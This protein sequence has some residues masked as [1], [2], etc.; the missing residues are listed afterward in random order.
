MP[1]ILPTAQNIPLAEYVHQRIARL[2]KIRPKKVFIGA[3]TPTRLVATSGSR[4]YPK[5]L[6]LRG[7]VSVA[8]K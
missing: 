5:T 1:L 4:Q 8:E 7:N 2:V 3:T 6:A